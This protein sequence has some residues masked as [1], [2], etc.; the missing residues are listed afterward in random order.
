[1]LSVFLLF[2]VPVLV[3]QNFEE[4]EKLLPDKNW[5]LFDEIGSYFKDIEEFRDIAMSVV[6]IFVFL[7]LFIDLQCFHLLFGSQM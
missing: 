4:L 5:S 6:M 7:N 2:A 1:M 3:V